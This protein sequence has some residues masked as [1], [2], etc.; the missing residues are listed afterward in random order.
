[1]AARLLG[2]DADAVARGGDPLA[3]APPATV[4]AVLEHRI[5][6]HL[7]ELLLRLLPSEEAASLYASAFEG[8][9]LQL[10]MHPTAN[11][12]VQSAVKPPETL[13]NQTIN[14]KMT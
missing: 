2:A 13:M 4:L 5:G 8:R 7:A 11:F 14:L 10:A 6:S 3:A 1:L 12:V 9:L